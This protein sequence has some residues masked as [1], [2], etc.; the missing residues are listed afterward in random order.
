MNICWPVGIHHSLGKVDGVTATAEST[1][2][3]HQMVRAE[4]DRMT[5]TTTMRAH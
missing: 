1:V 4:L 3:K 2:L 5:L